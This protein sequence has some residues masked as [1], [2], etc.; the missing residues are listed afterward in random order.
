[1]KRGNKKIASQPTNEVAYD[2]AIKTERASTVDTELAFP[3]TTPVNVNDNVSE[4]D[5]VVS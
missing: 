5:E 4:S 1:M 3:S 2:Q